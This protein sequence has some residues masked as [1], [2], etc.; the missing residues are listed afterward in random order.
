MV[1]F[2][3]A[4][5]DGTAKSWPLAFLVNVWFAASLRPCSFVQEW[6]RN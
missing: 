2:R 6:T 1:N 3:T 4:K 5:A